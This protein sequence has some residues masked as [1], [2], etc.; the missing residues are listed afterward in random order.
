MGADQVPLWVA[1][2]SKREEKLLDALNSLPLGSDLEPK[3]QLSYKEGV[4]SETQDSIWLY[5]PVNA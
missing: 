1:Y 5:G 2:N 3:F 4:S